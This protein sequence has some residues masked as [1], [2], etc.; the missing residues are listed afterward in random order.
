MKGC[1]IYQGE[2]QQ[3]CS[4]L[5]INDANAV[6]T[7]YVIIAYLLSNK[8]AIGKFR[9]PTAEGYNAITLADSNTQMNLV[10]TE[11]MTIA[12]TPGYPLEIE[13]KFIS[14]ETTITVRDEIYEEVKWAATQ[15]E[16]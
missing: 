13:A 14:G 6:L 8:N 4:Y 7:D 3:I 1:V 12:A 9:F 10:I 5:Q 16:A 2:Q 11:E 15:N